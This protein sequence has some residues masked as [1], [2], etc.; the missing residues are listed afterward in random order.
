MPNSLID[1]DAKVTTVSELP[2]QSI[3]IVGTGDSR[4]PEISTGM[5][6]ETPGKHVP[7]VVFNVVPPIIA[8]LVRFGHNFFVALVGSIGAGTLMDI[9]F[10]KCVTLA[11]S[12]AGAAVV[13]DLVTIF[14]NLENKYPLLTGSV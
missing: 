7:N 12:V 14:K 3:T 4:F 6:A 1:H 13:K 5:V 10:W 2:P 8:L 9:D 11:A